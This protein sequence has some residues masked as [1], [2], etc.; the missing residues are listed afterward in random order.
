MDF[1]IPPSP[2]IEFLRFFPHPPTIWTLRLL[3]TVEYKSYLLNNA[4]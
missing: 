2:Y 1:L 4:L 3:D